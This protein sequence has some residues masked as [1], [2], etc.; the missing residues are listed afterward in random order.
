MSKQ[1][2]HFVNSAKLKSANASND[3]DKKL[4]YQSFQDLRIASHIASASY[5]AIR[6]TGKAQ[7]NK[8][9]IQEECIEHYRTSTKVVGIT[10]V[11]LNPFLINKCNTL[12]QSPLPPAPSTPLPGV[13][14]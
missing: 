4:K 6:Q 7:M 2:L 5:D 10:D 12:H 1:A 14:F 3:S 9:R 13:N 11:T 8:V